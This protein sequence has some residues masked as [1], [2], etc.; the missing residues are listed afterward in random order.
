MDEVDDLSSIQE[1]KIIFTEK[2]DFFMNFLIQF[3]LLVNIVCRIC[4]ERKAF[5]QLSQIF[6]ECYIFI[7]VDILFYFI[8]TIKNLYGRV[9]INMQNK[10]K[11]KELSK[12]LLFLTFIHTFWALSIYQR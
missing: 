7:Y 1:S 3:I 2:M 8:Q 5:N 9:N 6:L 4:W 10:K 11:I 12:L